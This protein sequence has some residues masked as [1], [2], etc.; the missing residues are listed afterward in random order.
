MK[1]TIRNTLEVVI[2]LN[3]AQVGADPFEI[4]FVL[5]IA[6]QDESRDNALGSRGLHLGLDCAVPHVRCRCQ[7]GADGL[8]WHSKQG[9]TIVHYRLALSNPVG[10]VRVAEVF[11]DITVAVEGVHLID[12]IFADRRGRARIEGKRHARVA[13][14]ETKSSNTALAVF[15]DAGF[16][17]LAAATHRPSMGCRAVEPCCQKKLGTRAKLTTAAWRFLGAFLIQRARRWFC[18]DAGDA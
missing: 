8:G 13:A 7:N 4:D 6:K 16:R 5:D 11:G 17:T 12:L 10:L 15:C 14:T 1:L 3:I 2:G 18:E 9:V